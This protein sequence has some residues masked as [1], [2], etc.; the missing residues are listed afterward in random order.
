MNLPFFELGSA[1]QKSRN[2]DLKQQE[3]KMLP[4]RDPLKLWLCRSKGRSVSLGT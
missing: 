2:F 4:E 3:E 1:V